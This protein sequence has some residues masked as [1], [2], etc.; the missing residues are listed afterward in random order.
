M[1]D[2]LLAAVKDPN[3]GF[4]SIEEKDSEFEVLT[5]AAFRAFVHGSGYLNHAR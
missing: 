1:A 4:S 2:L 3:L 5:C